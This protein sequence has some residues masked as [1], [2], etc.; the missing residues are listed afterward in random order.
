MSKV[1][2]IL[3][4]HGSHIRHQTA[5]IVWQYVDQLRRLGVAHEVTACFWK[6]Q[7]AYYEVLDTVTAP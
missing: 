6:E 1:A 3:A 7:P 5:G 2:L 4:G